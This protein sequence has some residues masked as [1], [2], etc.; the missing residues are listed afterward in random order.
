MVVHVWAPEWDGFTLQYQ[1][2]GVGANGSF[3]FTPGGGTQGSEGW[4]VT[5]SIGKGVWM[6]ME[7][8]RS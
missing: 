4:D 1:V 5:N 2:A 3:E 8:A 6:A 7:N